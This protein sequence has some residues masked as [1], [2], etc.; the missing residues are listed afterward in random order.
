MK[1]TS[2]LLIGPRVTRHADWRRWLRP[3]AFQKIIAVDAGVRQAARLGLQPDLSVGDWDSLRDPA[4]LGQLKKKA[5]VSLSPRKDRSDFFHALSLLPPTTRSLVALGF[6]GGRLDHELAVLWDAAEWIKGASKRRLDLWSA[7]EKLTLLGAGEKMTLRVKPNALVS[8]F[9]M[10]PRCAGVT[11]RG[12]DY[13]LVNASLGQGSLGLSN[14]VVQ[15]TATVSHRSGVLL[16]WVREGWN[17]KGR[18][19]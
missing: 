14:R 15:S 13:P 3:F 4:L 16:V 8:V 2:I 17:G 5:H 1:R 10:T 19:A 12:F 9:S 6:R 18:S 11:L 7:T